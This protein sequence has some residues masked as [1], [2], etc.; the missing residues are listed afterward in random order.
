M[1]SAIQLL[2]NKAN[3]AAL[4]CHHLYDQLQ[5]GCKAMINK[6]WQKIMSSTFCLLMVFIMT[7]A[8]ASP[9]IGSNEK[10]IT[11]K[12]VP[13]PLDQAFVFSFEMINSKQVQV[14][15]QIAPGYYL[16]RSKFHFTVFPKRK[17]L[18]EYPQVTKNLT[19]DRGQ[20]F[21]YSGQLVIP[22]L[23]EQS[24]YQTTHTKNQ[25]KKTQPLE[26]RIDY[27]G[28]SEKGFCYP[29]V[30]TKI[31]LPA[32]PS[33]LP[34]VKNIVESSSNI[35]SFTS[36]RT[37]LTDQ[38]G[39]LALF[40]IQNLGIQLIIF[41]VLGL[42]LAFTPCVLPMIPI[43]T[44]I[45]I[46]QQKKSNK[47]TFLLASSYV[48]GMACT[49]SLAG[50][51]AASLGSS[52]QVWVQKPI[53][54]SLGSFIFI[55]LAF[56]LFGFY[57]LRLPLALQNKIM[58]LSHGQGGTY[59]SVFCMGVISTL[60]VSPCV[61]APL[62]GVLLYMGQSGNKLLGGTAL[63]AMG[64]GMGIPL[65]L[66]AVSAGKYLPKSG[67]WMEVVKK[68]FGVL[69]LLM[70]VWLLSR[71]ISASA[72]Y[73]LLGL[74][75]LITAL[76]FIY[77]RSP[78]KGWIKFHYAC[79]VLLTIAGLWMFAM[80]FFPSLTQ[81]KYTPWLQPSN[82]SSAFVVVKNVKELNRQLAVAK[83][84]KRPVLLDFY[85]DWCESCLVLDKKIF[86]LSEVQTV[87]NR[88]VRIRADLS[89]NSTEDEILLKQFNVI[90]PPTIIFFNSDGQEDDMRII[91]EVNKEEFLTKVNYFIT[92][93]CNKNMT[94]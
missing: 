42:L 86:S 3:G 6:Q 25:N 79:G 32:Q 54:I 8:Y 15:W 85:A 55:L 46:G 11:E 26:L 73:F 7:F 58:R 39:V 51:I 87:L 29:P 84:D 50:L 75:S 27:Q 35:Q 56:S 91:G 52:L 71:I 36:L 4:S 18:I 62:I 23:F 67:P 28:C 93:S 47:R 1:T 22:I 70:A 31:N 12:N 49:Y 21:V 17:F 83:A 43:L 89:E 33:H 38:N 90:A 94:C 78:A 72:I 63:F 44:S 82:V 40:N 24:I 64:I 88:F 60:I 76:F 45:I 34:Q 41:V 74:I 9:H 57:H 68:M 5:R 30:T 61:T 81:G 20:Y 16:Y 14:K 92:A 77:S 80:S 66:I 2:D 19:E 37:L 59:L 69:M 10:K 65:L 48:L 53:F 13:L